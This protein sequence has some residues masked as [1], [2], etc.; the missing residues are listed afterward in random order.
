[1]PEA[2]FALG[3]IIHMIKENIRF[4]KDNLFW[5]HPPFKK[6]SNFWGGNPIAPLFYAN[7]YFS[8][9]FLTRVIL[10]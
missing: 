3:F 6:L 1:M 5:L 2:L 4:G 10:S 7:V 8:N 9:L